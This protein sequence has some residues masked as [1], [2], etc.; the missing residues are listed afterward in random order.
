MPDARYARVPRC[1]P[2]LDT[3]CRESKSRCVRTRRLLPGP[4]QTFACPTAATF[5]F[6]GAVPMSLRAAACM[7]PVFF[8]VATV[9]VG[10]APQ[11]SI[12]G[13]FHVAT[14]GMGFSMG[15]TNLQG[16]FRPLGT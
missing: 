11:V 3:G 8:V 1:R 16:C 14:P 12:A 5:C 6:P 4:L 15:W 10:H 2:G 7:A 9:L 13:T